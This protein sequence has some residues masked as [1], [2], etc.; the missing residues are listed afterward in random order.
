MRTGG[1]K[2]G[3]G[4]ELWEGS[5]NSGRKRVTKLEIEKNYKGGD[6]RGWDGNRI[7]GDG[8]NG[9]IEFRGEVNVH[10]SSSSFSLFI[11]VRS[12]CTRIILSGI[13]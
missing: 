7:V 9:K 3:W 5:R 12:P 2:G 4:Y 11:P 6:G 8:E 10:L 1:I 13:T